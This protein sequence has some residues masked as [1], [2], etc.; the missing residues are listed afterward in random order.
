[1]R[2]FYVITLM[3][4][5]FVVYSCTSFSKP[6]QIETVRIESID[7]NKLLDIQKSKGS[8]FL[9]EWANSSINLI[10][11]NPD[12][13]QNSR[14]LSYGSTSDY[15]YS[16]Q[17]PAAFTVSGM[18]VSTVDNTEIS[19]DEV[20]TGE[21]PATNNLAFVTW[22]D[23]FNSPFEDMVFIPG[24]TF[25]MGSKFNKDELPK[26][27]VTISGF[28]MDKYEVTVAQFREFCRATRRA[29]PKQPNWN[30]DRHPVVNVSWANAAA[31]AKWKGK[32]LPTEAEW[33]FA[34]RSGDRQ[35]YYSWGNVKPVRKRG[36]NIADESILME[37]RNWKIWK[38]Y[39]DGFVYTAPVG[40]F[41]PNQFGVHD[42]TG[43]AMEWCADWY[44]ADYYKK[45]PNID[46]QGPAKGS[47]KVLR[48]GSWNLSPRKILTTKRYYF[49]QDVVIN[50]VG[51]R[52][53]KD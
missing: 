6:L 15:E 8:T 29:M 45:S 31:Y 53:V 20:H 47:H 30:N 5:T 52:C 3:L 2:F 36:G 44:Q 11:K 24:G 42:L 32:R 33:E 43:N 34:A 18:I 39:Y 17:S 14:T 4:M 25:T 23:A 7:V 51:F 12:A 1:M 41:Y 13:P 37:K 49:R 16:Y 19:W 40:S 21:N 27:R 35:Y 38:G 26:H 9:A 22:A 28:Y 46:P 10:S 48:G 50:Y